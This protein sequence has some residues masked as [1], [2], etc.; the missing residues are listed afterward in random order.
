M[1]AS[2]IRHWWMGS[3]G[4]V[5]NLQG[6]PLAIY[7]TFKLRSAYI[8]SGLRIRRTS[9]STTLD[10]GF[11]NSKL[12]KTAID[13]FSSNG[14]IPLTCVIIYDQSGNGYDL[15]LE[16][17]F[18]EAPVYY[19]T[20]HSNY[21]LRF[22]PATSGNAPVG[23]ANT[24]YRNATISVNTRSFSQYTIVRGRKV[25]PVASTAYFEWG[26]SGAL[27]AQITTVRHDMYDGALKNA[28]ANYLVNSVDFNV[29]SVRTN[30]GTNIKI[31][32]DNLFNTTCA[33]I[34]NTTPTGMRIGSFSA[35]TA[36]KMEPDWIGSVVYNTGLIDADDALNVSTIHSILNKT[37]LH[38]EL[39]VCLGD[40]LTAGLGL[41]KT[42]TWQTQLYRQYSQSVRWINSGVA[43]DTLDLMNSAI[44][45][46]AISYLTTPTFSVTPTKKIC[47]LWGGTNNIFA[48]ESGASTYTKYT[49]L[50]NALRTAGF[51][52]I[53]GMNIIRRDQFT[54]P[55]LVEQAAFNSALASNHSFL[56]GYVDL[57]ALTWAQPATFQSDGAHLNPAGVTQLI[58]ALKPVLD[59]II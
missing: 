6:S 45:D 27:Y 4:V 28:A 46:R 41:Q 50:A 24:S 56:D 9:D 39:V 7:S 31:G 25:T 26:S 33:V 15:T 10:V 19:D 43:S 16:A 20:Y 23:A 17:T 13:A 1:R 54:A 55:M 29:H 5:Y 8:G 53:I 11:V 34:A 38:S 57:A 32:V 30:G 37:V 18:A 48:S 58:G 47:I 3:S 42:E 14:S 12:D 44:T 2:L 49:N 21:I 52:H 51:T 35:S 59:T 22:V 36:Y 40:S